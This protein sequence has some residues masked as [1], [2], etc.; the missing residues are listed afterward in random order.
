MSLY[1][2]LIPANGKE[3]K[4]KKNIFLSL[5]PR[6][7]CTIRRSR[8]RMSIYVIHVKC[9][10]R[11]TVFVRIHLVTYY[12]AAVG[13][14]GQVERCERVKDTRIVAAGSRLWFFLKPLPSL[15]YKYMYVYNI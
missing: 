3:K 8:D 10:R 6:S 12:Y 7:L 4:G 14:S 9:I 15:L 5:R 11:H 13:V 1:N 2:Y